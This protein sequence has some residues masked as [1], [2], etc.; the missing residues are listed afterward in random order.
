MLN[1]ILFLR[2]LR[3]LTVIDY[4]SAPKTHP[5]MHGLEKMTLL[6]LGLT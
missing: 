5:Q 3:P 1:N 4:W 6:D 2:N